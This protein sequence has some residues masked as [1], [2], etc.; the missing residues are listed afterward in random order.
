MH[1]LTAV[2]NIWKTAKIIKVILPTITS[3]KCQ[4]VNETEMYTILMFGACSFV[5]ALRNCL[6]TAVATVQCSDCLDNQPCCFS[7]N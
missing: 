4:C 3:P 1:L 2:S 6:L 5:L 7:H